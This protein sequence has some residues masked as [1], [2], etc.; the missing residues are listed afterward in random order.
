MISEY[1]GLD[2]ESITRS[3]AHHLEFTQFENRNTAVDYDIFA[4]L[5]FAIRDR[6]IE[7]SNDTQESLIFHKSKRVY[8]LS[9]EYLMGRSLKNNINC[10]DLHDTVKETLD[11]IGYDLSEIEEV[12]VEPGLGNGGL[13]STK[14]KTKNKKQKT[15]NKKQKTKNKKQKTKNKKQKTK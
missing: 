15:K 8:Y 6:L 12:E 4:S 5:A 3:I 11:D 13:G 2:K 14:Q 7:F 1:Q 9:L 10:L